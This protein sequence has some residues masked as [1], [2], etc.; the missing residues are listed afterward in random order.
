MLLNRASVNY[1][2]CLRFMTVV[3]MGTNSCSTQHQ[4]QVK[5]AAEFA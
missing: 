3:D 2:S 5:T 1:G 4:A